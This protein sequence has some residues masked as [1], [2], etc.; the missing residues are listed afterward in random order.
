MSLSQEAI[1]ALVGLVIALP[2]TYLALRYCFRRARP[3][4]I[5]DHGLEGTAQGVLPNY[6]MA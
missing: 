3:T 6:R 5:H 4:T 2:P 1:V